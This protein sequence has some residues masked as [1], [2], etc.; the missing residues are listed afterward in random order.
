MTF[1][2]PPFALLFPG[3]GA[4]YVG[5]GKEIYQESPRAREIF[6]KADEMMAFPLSKLCFEGPEPQ[7]NLTV[8]S[9][10]AIF[11]TSLAIWESVKQIRKELRPSL[12]CGLS[13]GE[14]SALT[15]ADVL[16]FQSCLALV[17]KRGQW[18]HEAGNQHPG[19]M[20][21]VIG[22][23][24][25]LCEQTAAE[26]GAQIA[27]YNSPGQIVLSGSNSA[28][29]K[30]MEIA[31]MKGA[32]K[33]IPLKVS[34]AFHS[35]LMSSAQEKLQ[36]ELAKTSFKAPSIGF[37]S[38][39]TA[40]FS[41]QPEEIRNRLALQVT[42]SVRWY[43]SLEL[44]FEKGIRHAIE[45]GPGKVLKGLAKRTVPELNVFNIETPQ[46]ISGLESFFQGAPAK[47]QP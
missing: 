39:V 24:T 43:Q 1:Q 5:M 37:I 18:M 13:L 33:L 31:K 16:D 11:V 19:A 32:K 42:H 3:Q 10:P 40:D 38:N 44:I 6:A 45:V 12:T 35:N 17:R 41:V 28:I 8:N 46:D 34:G 47:A 27:N 22:L 2:I 4:Q 36:Q 23:D 30:A 9:Q 25:A 21:S 29:E 15:S 14:F 26:S 7:L 20:C